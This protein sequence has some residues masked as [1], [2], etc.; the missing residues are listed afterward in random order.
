MGGVNSSVGSAKK[1]IA[2]IGSLRVHVNVIPWNKVPGLDFAEPSREDIDIYV[3][4]LEAAGIVAA[5][6]MR[7]G[8][9]VMGACGQLGDTLRAPIEARD[10]DIA[11]PWPL[12]SRPI[13]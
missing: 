3:A 2:W 5:R 13:L 8:R 11:R 1:L 9:G 6:R 10:H 7:R 4:T 12:P